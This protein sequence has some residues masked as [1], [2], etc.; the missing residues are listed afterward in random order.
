MTPATLGR[1][2]YLEGKPRTAN[3]YSE[4]NPSRAVWFTAW[5]AAKKADNLS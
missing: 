3:P 2:A 4:R 5:D 1:E